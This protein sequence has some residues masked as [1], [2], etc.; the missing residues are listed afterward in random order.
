MGCGNTKEKIEDELM[1]AKMERIEIQ[2]E[3]QRQM[4]ILKELGCD[5]EYKQPIIPDYTNP[6]VENEKGPI[7]RK[8]KT[9]QFNKQKTARVRTIRSKSFVFKNQ[10]SINGED[11][12][13][14]AKIKQK[15]SL[16]KS[17][18]M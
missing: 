15:K 18:Q 6:Q 14:E 1:N 16:K 7:V 12:H 4:N 3:R 5:S 9:L 2:Y 10:N 8:H 17:N 11:A 13:S